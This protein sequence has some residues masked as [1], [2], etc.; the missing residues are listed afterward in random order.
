MENKPII[1]VNRLSKAKVNSEETSIKEKK[2]EEKIIYYT[3]KCTRALYAV[4]RNSLCLA[5]RCPSV[6]VFCF[7]VLACK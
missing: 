1:N 7:V 4:F 2:L 3:G 6:C 5:L